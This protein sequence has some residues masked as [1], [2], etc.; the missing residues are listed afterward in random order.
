[1]LEMS[2]DMLCGQSAIS[3]RNLKKYQ[4]KINRDLSVIQQIIKH[5]RVDCLMEHVLHLA[6]HDLNLYAQSYAPCL[7]AHGLNKKSKI[8]LSTSKRSQGIPSIASGQQNDTAN[9]NEIINEVDNTNENENEIENENDNNNNNNNEETKHEFVSMYRE[10][11]SIFIRI[12]GGF[13]TNA[14]V[15][16]Y[17]KSEMLCECIL[18][19]SND[20][21]EIMFTQNLSHPQKGISVK[22]GILSL[23]NSALILLINDILAFLPVHFFNPLFFIMLPFIFKLMLEKSIPFCLSNVPGPLPLQWNED[24]VT[25]TKTFK[26]EASFPMPGSGGDL[27][28][29]SPMCFEIEFQLH[30]HDNEEVQAETKRTHRYVYVPSY[31]WS[32]YVRQEEFFSVEYW[33][34][35]LQHVSCPHGQIFR[36]VEPSSSSSSSSP[37]SSV[38]LRFVHNNSMKFGHLTRMFG[39]CY[40]ICA[41]YNIVQDFLKF[42][43]AKNDLMVLPVCCHKLYMPYTFYQIKQ[44][45]ITLETV[46]L[47][48]R[49]AI[50]GMT[51]SSCSNKKYIYVFF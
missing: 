10:S 31:Q 40:R 13:E 41:V 2:N 11:E 21:G 4:S 32:C 36:A 39:Y 12:P 28:L 29:L 34:L 16:I 30:C 15:V 38:E 6:T 23:K 20:C 50:L 14:F 44:V 17:F 3:H 22:Q 49:F 26:V 42:S 24:L 25:K 19:L 5:A 45:F 33:D 48:I 35:I 1:M 27:L 9:D 51:F 47:Q 37:S 8:A 18:V 7:Q 46:I 43:T